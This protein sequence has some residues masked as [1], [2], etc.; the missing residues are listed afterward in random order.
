ME[1]GKS[2]K[3]IMHSSLGDIFLCCSL[4]HLSNLLGRQA[5]QASFSE[6][7]V[8]SAAIRSQAGGRGGGSMVHWRAVWAVQL[9]TRIHFS[10]RQG[11]DLMRVVFQPQS[12]KC[13]TSSFF[14][15][16]LNQALVT[17][18]LAI[19]SPWRLAARHR[20]KEGGISYLWRI[21]FQP[22]ISET[23]C[24]DTLHC[25]QY[26]ASVAAVLLS[27]HS[28]PSLSA[29]PVSP[30]IEASLSAAAFASIRFVSLLSLLA[31]C[32]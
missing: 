10:V 25:T 28:T 14:H 30:R 20:H 27:I 11:I 31:P 12:F 4:R 32:H 1:A 22:T 18:Y 13:S 2:R 24:R 8:Q 5:S 6:G 29:L 16:Q 26:A 17:N 7:K 15:S 3:L 9:L 23:T 19:G 21:R